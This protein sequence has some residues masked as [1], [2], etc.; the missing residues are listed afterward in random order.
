META[1]ANDSPSSAGRGLKAVLT[2]A[3][4]PGKDNN[5][6]THSVNSTNNSSE[7]H[8]VRS[9]IDSFGD[10]LRIPRRSSVD[11]SPASL[12]VRKLSKLIPRRISK[13]VGRHGEKES[14]EPI[15]E[16]DEAGE[17]ERLSRSQKTI[18]Q[19]GGGSS[20]TT[21]ESETES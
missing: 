17:A 3:R 16:G 13:K 1:T 18:G 19:D 7:G 2:K 12:K 8:G 21:N 15:R 5:S 6:S 20:L 14:K 11:D 10:K 4:R 9:S